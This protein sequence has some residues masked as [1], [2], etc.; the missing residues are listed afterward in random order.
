MQEDVSA[1]LFYKDIDATLSIFNNNIK[2]YIYLS[3]LTDVN[4][5]AIVNAQGD[6]TY[7]YQQSSAQ[8]YGLEISTCFHP[9]IMRGF[10][11]D[12]A[13]SLIY[14]YN[15][16]T[17]YKNK[18]KE[19]EYLPLIPPAKL[20]SSLSQEIK[21][22]SKTIPSVN[23]RAEMEY[24][25]EQNRYLELNNTETAT[26]SYT[27]FNFSINTQ[28]NYSE[29]NKVELQLQVN[30]AFDKAYQSNLSRLKYFEYYTASPNGHTGMFNMGRNICLKAIFSF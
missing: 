2:N 7:Q 22:K 19:G 15:R 30:N 23:V 28:I 29:R 10:S 11:F 20:L 21:I 27:L 14:G 17:N 9:S 12:N 13:F 18:G 24:D 16:K 5:N 8:L 26:P 4:G 1:E 3:Q 25:A 6:K